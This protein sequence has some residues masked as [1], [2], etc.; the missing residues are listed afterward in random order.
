MTGLFVTGTDTGVG[1][2]VIAA[3][4]AARWARQGQ[5]VRVRKPVISGVAESTVPEPPPVDDLAGLAD[6]RLLWEAAGRRGALGEVCFHRFGAAVAPSVAQDLGETPLEFQALA[7]WL[8]SE[9][10]D[11]QGPTLVEGVG[12]WR[13]W[14]DDQHGVADL[15][16][17]AALPVLVVAANRL[18]AINHSVLSV[19]AV[20]RDGFEVA[21][22]VLN[23]G[24]IPDPTGDEA[25]ARRSN[26]AELRQRLPVPVLPFPP[27]ERLTLAEL[28]GAGGELV[29]AL[30]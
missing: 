29:A 11:A 28:E 27:L 24:A 19:E 5:S 1:K 8:R 13:V 22:V 6:D 10:R 15:A 16:R 14:I 2:T 18:G 7:S 21:A 23:D 25:D 9:L 12:G 17:I 30:S 20:L 26:L 3:A 4:L